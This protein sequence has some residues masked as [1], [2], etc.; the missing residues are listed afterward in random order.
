MKLLYQ[1]KTPQGGIEF[2]VRFTGF[3]SQGYYEF[4]VVAHDSAQAKQMWYEFIDSIDSTAKTSNGYDILSGWKMAEK[5]SQNSWD[6]GYIRWKSLRHT[7]RDIGV[8]EGTYTS[9]F[10]GSDH[11]WD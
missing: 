2:R 1:P 4:P 5:Y 3:A 8:Y 7:N 11:L 6:G 9:T 10:A